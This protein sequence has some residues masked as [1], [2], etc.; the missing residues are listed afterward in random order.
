MAQDGAAK[1]A[2]KLLLINVIRCV[3]FCTP[4][5]FLDYEA[6]PLAKNNCVRY[7]NDD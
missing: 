2:L 1:A 4:F 5:R 7:K 3:R 6:T